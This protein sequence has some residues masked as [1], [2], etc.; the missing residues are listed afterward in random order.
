VPSRDSHPHLQSHH[1][2]EVDLLLTTIHIPTGTWFDF[3]SLAPSID[4]ESMPGAV[5]ARTMCS[6]D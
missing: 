3:F 5:M 6:N 1:S 2:T 4:C